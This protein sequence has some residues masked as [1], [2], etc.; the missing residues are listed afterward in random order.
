MFG[1]IGGALELKVAGTGANL[2]DAPVRARAGRWLS[3]LRSVAE[4]LSVEVHL[5]APRGAGFEMGLG[6]CPPD[7]RASAGCFRW[8]S[9]L[10]GG[11]PC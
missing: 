5:I 2:G 9:F 6:G 7:S 8:T 11:G 3:G 1:V 4:G 10:S